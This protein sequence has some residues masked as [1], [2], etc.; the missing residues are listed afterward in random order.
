[1]TAAWRA[2]HN[3]LIPSR[4]VSSDDPWSAATNCGR[5]TPQPAVKHTSPYQSPRS[6]AAIKSAGGEASAVYL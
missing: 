3:G 5:S 1:M 6:V 4:R 2:I